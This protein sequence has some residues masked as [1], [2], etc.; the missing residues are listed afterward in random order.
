MKGNFHVRFGSGEKPEIISK[1]YLSTYTLNIKSVF[2][3]EATEECLKWIN[4]KGYLLNI[5]GELIRDM[6]KDFI[7]TCYCLTNTKD[8]LT[9]DCNTKV[10]AY[11]I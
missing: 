8:K 5:Q 6:T 4:S 9:E 3:K 2:S 10:P 1:S 11:V 7:L